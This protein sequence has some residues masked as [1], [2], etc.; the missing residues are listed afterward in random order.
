M[1]NQNQVKLAPIGLVPHLPEYKFER[2]TKA[3]AVLLEPLQDH[4]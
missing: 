3:M 1:L 4:L 2:L